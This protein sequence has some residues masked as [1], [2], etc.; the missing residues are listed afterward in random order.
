MECRGSSKLT[1]EAV[2][3]IYNL[4][5]YSDMPTKEISKKYNISKS[6]VLAIKTGYSWASVTRH[7]FFH[8]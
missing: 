6:A 5:W 1:E 7:I 8:L 2:T 4:A 3:E